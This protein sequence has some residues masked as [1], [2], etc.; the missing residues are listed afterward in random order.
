[1]NN[2]PMYDREALRR[3]FA[4][5]RVQA[6]SQKPLGRVLLL[7]LGKPQQPSKLT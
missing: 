2:N 3:L 1:M 4:E 7:A 5:A 6:A